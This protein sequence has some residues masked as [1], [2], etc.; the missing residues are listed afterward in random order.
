TTLASLSILARMLPRLRFR[1]DR[2]AGAGSDPALLA[3][4]AADYLVARGVPF[5]EAHEVVGRA[6]RRAAAKKL[7]LAELDLAQWRALHPSFESDVA[8][9]F[10]ARRA[11]ARRSLVGS[12]GPAAVKRAIVRAVVAVKRNRRW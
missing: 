2:L 6:V 9:V 10:D 12:P 1:V 11:L 4:E 3:T 8:E 7:S 5:R